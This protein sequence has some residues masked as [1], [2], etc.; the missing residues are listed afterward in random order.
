M[1]LIG[2]VGGVHWGG[3]TGSCYQSLVNLGGAEA[4]V[5]MRG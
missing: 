3:L 4:G 2:G 5:E 1:K